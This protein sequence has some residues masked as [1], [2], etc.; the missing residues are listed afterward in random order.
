MAHNVFDGL[1][2]ISI[3]NKRIF[4]KGIIG[5]LK[6]RKSQRRENLA[7]KAMISILFVSLVMVF[8]FKLSDNNERIF[9]ANID[10]IITI[11]VSENRNQELYYRSE[12]RLSNGV[13]FYSEAL[14]EI[15]EL[16][17]ISIDKNRI[18]NDFLL[19]ALAANSPGEKSVEIIHYDINNRV[20]D[21]ERKKIFFHR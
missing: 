13:Y 11:K 17:K 14:P 1:S 16:K 20:L 6:Y 18:G 5:K 9:S 12:V 21:I 7:Y 4:R 19:I 2:K 3:K 10:D 8:N 15:A